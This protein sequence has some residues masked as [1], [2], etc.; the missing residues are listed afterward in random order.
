MTWCGALTGML[1]LGCSQRATHPQKAE[2]KIS[3]LLLCKQGYVCVW[4]SVLWL[5]LPSTLSSLT[6]S[7]L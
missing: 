5:F 3:S 6:F 2:R 7:I 1:D 4:F